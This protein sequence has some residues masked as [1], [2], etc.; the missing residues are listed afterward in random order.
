MHTANKN[1]GIWF[2][3]PLGK[4]WLQLSQF[5][6]KNLKE[7]WHQSKQ[8]SHGCTGHNNTL[9]AYSF[10]AWWMSISSSKYKSWTE[11]QRLSE[12]SQTVTNPFLEGE[13]YC[14]LEGKEGAATERRRLQTHIHKQSLLRNTLDPVCPLYR[15][16]TADGKCFAI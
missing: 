14:E 5:L 10:G 9:D 11:R 1:S 13:F 6:V 16:S 8:I 3:M 2:K 12:E 7:V 15:D 4:T